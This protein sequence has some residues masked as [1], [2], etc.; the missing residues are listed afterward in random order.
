MEGA[1][2][3]V[4]EN[5]FERDPKARV[6]SI[7][8]HDRNAPCLQIK[9]PSVRSS[10]SED[11]RLFTGLEIVDHNIHWNWSILR[12]DCVAYLAD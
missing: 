10:K 1:V 4:L 9:M 3:T 12:S 8:H 7:K 5:R 6:V 11:L 2:S